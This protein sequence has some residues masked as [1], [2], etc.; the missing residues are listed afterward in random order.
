MSA[1]R[2]AIVI[3]AALTLTACATTDERGTAGA[4]PQRSGTMVDTDH[5]YVAHVESIARRRG[6]DVQWIHMPTKRTT[7][8][9]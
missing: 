3:A 5:E 2:T 7:R 1:L 8:E 4:A 9:D 6:I